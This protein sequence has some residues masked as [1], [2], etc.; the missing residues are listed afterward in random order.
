V[1]YF[2]AAVAAGAVKTILRLSF[3]PNPPPIKMKKNNELT[4]LVK[5]CSKLNA[6]IIYFSQISMWSLQVL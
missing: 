1:T 6:I 2:A 4:R 5:K 3:P